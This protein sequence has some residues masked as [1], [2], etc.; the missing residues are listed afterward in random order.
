MFQKIKNV[1][2]GLMRKRS[3]SYVALPV[4]A[5]MFLFYGPSREA[6]NA[7]AGA[8]NGEVFGADVHEGQEN[9]EPHEYF[10]WGGL[11]ARINPDL[12]HSQ[13][14]EIGKAVSDHS[15]EYNL[16][17]QLI[18]ATII[19]ESGGRLDAVSPRGARGLMQVM[20]FWMEEF[21]LEGRD[22][23]KIDTNI[24]VG[25]RILSEYIG[26][27]GY[28]EGILRYYRGGLPSDDRYYFKVQKVMKTL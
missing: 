22:L 10:Y 26:K 2:D 15:R 21:G 28:K 19:V 25:C 1:L 5:L 17:P 13:I 18:V 3:R 12:T 14:Y 9:P 23:F 6:L 8:I 27:W 24:R 16:S 20:P 7:V 4:I 11:L